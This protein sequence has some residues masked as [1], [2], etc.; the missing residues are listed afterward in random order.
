MR[1]LFAVYPSHAHFWPQVPCAWALQSAGHEVRVATHARFAGSVT[2]AGLIPVG[3]GDPAADEARTRP[4]ARAPSPPEEVAHFADVLGLDREQREHWIAFYQYLL[5][6]ISDYLRTDL[7]Y[8]GQLID[9]A[10]AWRPDLVIWDPTFACAP[11]AARLCGA[12]HARLFLGPDYPRWSLDRLAER[13]DAVRA[14]GLPENPLLDLIRPLAE[15]YRVELDGELATGQWSIDAMPPGLAL[16]AGGTR[17]PI[18]HVPFTGAE[19]FPEWLHRTPRRPRVALSLGES[20]R[21]YIKGDWGRIPKLLAAVSE[22]DIELVATVNSLQLEGVE[23]I[24]DNV[25]TIDFV[26]LTQ[27]LP[28][29]TALIHHGGIGTFGAACAF[30]LPQIVC[31]TDESVMLRPVEVDPRTMTGGTYRIGY[32]FGV[33]EQ[34][35]ETVTTWELPAKKLEAAPTARYVV[36]RGAG[37]RLDHQRQSTAE[38][39]SLIQDV[40]T[41]QSYRDGARAVYD[42]WLAMP[43]PAA[44][45]PQLERLAAEH[46]R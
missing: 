20:T 27:L 13:R 2:A 26:P 8:P 5:N 28:T 3:L 15:Q 33:S 32:E 12:A 40:V 31:D 16:P 24:P 36:S 30:R 37:A 29:C 11:V 9:F 25:R 17:L 35:V 4:D 38:I 7:P 23:R 1:V 22:L 39:A 46:R 34:V 6:P 18:R 42:S 10:R 44:V 14:A 41:G 21:R 45:V 19:P 43:S